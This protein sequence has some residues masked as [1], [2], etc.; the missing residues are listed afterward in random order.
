M[1]GNING[2]SRTSGMTRAGLGIVVITLLSDLTAAAIKVAAWNAAR[3]ACSRFCNGCA[4]GY[5]A[6]GPQRTLCLCIVCGG[7][8]C[9]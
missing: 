6:N 4:D 3:T 2:P 1:H 9:C 8:T 7:H 5:L